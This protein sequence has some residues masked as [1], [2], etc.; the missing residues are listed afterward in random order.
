MIF[1]QLRTLL[2]LL[3]SHL[4]LTTTT[5]AHTGHPS[6][7]APQPTNPA[8]TLWASTNIAVPIV[9][10]EQHI[11]QP[12]IVPIQLSR[13]PQQFLTHTE[14]IDLPTPQPPQG[15]LPYAQPLSIILIFC[16]VLGFISTFT[17]SPF[18]FQMSSSSSKPPG[19]SSS[20]ST[21]KPSSSS[22]SPSSPSSAPKPSSPQPVP[23]ISA[24]A[25]MS[26]F[27]FCCL[28]LIILQGPLGLTGGGALPGVA[29]WTQWPKFGGGGGGGW[30]TGWD[31]LG[32]G[33]APGCVGVVAGMVPWCQPQVQQPPPQP[34]LVPP[35]SQVQIQQIVQN[36]PLPP[37]YQSPRQRIVSHQP[38]AG[39]GA[40]MGGQ[41]GFATPE[42]GGGWSWYANGPSSASPGSVRQY[43]G[44]KF[45]S[46]LLL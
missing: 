44:R 17:T 10:R 46:F 28:V 31:G 32:L 21:S 36:P 42:G 3:A 12:N 34:P 13:Q 41:G 33:G 2:L 7:W 43:T 23:T 19:S 22:S 8:D 45:I 29:Q 16:A 40:Q 30:W 5:L 9:T 37:Y 24:N 4:V 27:L 18:S 11:P 1:A 38:A 15:V 39:V 25:W 6:H 14:T 20:S 35:L 26:F